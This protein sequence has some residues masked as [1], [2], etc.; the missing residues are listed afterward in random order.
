L[1]WRRQARLE[2]ITIGAGVAGCT[3][4]ALVTVERLIGSTTLGTAR[5]RVTV[6]VN[7]AVGACP[8]SGTNTRIAGESDVRAIAAIF[9]GCC[10]AGHHTF[11][12]VAAE[13][14]GAGACVRRKVG[15]VRAD[16]AV[17]AGSGG[18]WD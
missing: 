2:Y 11:A 13:S 10:E 18:A 8:R 6:R 5:I 12:I 16:T 7:V 4:K 9:A 3:A 17:E 14:E 15:G 1:T